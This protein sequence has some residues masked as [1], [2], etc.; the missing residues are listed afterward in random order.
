MSTEA[1]AEHVTPH[2]R[3]TGQGA[4]LCTLLEVSD[5]RAAGIIDISLVDETHRF[6][7]SADGTRCHF[8]GQLTVS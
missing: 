5:G 2:A 7:L 6:G 3:G 8:E 1:K 4:K